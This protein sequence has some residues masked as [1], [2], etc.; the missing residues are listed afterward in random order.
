MWNTRNA[1]GTLKTQCLLV[2]VFFTAVQPRTDDEGDHSM[3]EEEL[4]AESH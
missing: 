2:R 4:F 1:S 3:E